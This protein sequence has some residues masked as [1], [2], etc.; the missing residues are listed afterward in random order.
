[1]LK[2][3]SAQRKAIMEFRI[4][5]C[6]PDSTNSPLGDLSNPIHPSFD[7][8]KMLQEVE[9]DSITAF[10]MISSTAYEALKPTLR[11]ASLLITEP[12]ML[13]PFDHVANGI[14]TS[15]DNGTY[16]ASSGRYHTSSVHSCMVAVFP[17]EVLVLVIR[18]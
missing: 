4:E 7:P 1:M 9:T 12:A 17:R 16:L 15:N 6:G 14:I 2:F 13:G 18:S 5:A 11:L 8:S 10:R 3:T